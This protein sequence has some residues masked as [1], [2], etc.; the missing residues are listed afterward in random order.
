MKTLPVSTGSKRIW[1]RGEQHSDMRADDNSRE[2][3]A[4][5]A[6]TRHRAGHRDQNGEGKQEPGLLPY[7][8]TMTYR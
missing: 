8:I 5:I 6:Q 3:V 4:R 7:E 2:N 1:Y